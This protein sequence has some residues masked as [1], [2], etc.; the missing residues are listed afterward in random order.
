MFTGLV[1]AVGRIESFLPTPAGARLRLDPQGWNHSAASGDSIA[2]AG[3][4]LTVA[5]SPASSSA[6]LEFNLVPETIARTTFQSLRPGA[7]VNLER[8]LRAGDLLGGHLV[9]GHIDGAGTVREIRTAGEYRLTIAAPADLVPRERLAVEY[10]RAVMRDSNRVP[11]PL[12]EELHAAFTDP[13]LVELS[14]LI[15]YINMLN[16]F[17]NSLGV[18]YHGDYRVLA[19]AA[20]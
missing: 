13:E 16:L 5:N 1:Q 15:G 2:V 8:S 20:G 4:C 18:R 17:N 7:R 10:T 9:Q 3:C 14:F 11:D 19:S 12:W 6:P